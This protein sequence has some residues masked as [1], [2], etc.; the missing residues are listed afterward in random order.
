MQLCFDQGAWPRR[1]YTYESNP[2]W[3]QLQYL[4]A[5]RAAFAYESKVTAGAA[6]RRM[7][8]NLARYSIASDCQGRPEQH[9]IVGVRNQI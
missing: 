6:G 4:C 8:W 7:V 9:R 2:A 1:C 5:F 3:Y